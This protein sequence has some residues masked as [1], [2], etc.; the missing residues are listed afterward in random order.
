MRYLFKF[1]CVCGLGAV[2][3]VG[4]SEGGGKGGSGGS[5]GSGGT[6]GS[7]GTAGSG[8]TGGSGVACVDNVC[9]C[10][11]PGIRAAISEGGGPFTFD[12]DGPQTVVTEATFIINTDVI[13]D[14]E[15]N[16]TVALGPPSSDFLNRVFAF[17]VP[18]GVK[19]ELHRLTTD[20]MPTWDPGT[21]GIVNEGTLTIRDCVITGHQSERGPPWRGGGVFNAG[22]MTIINST[23]SKNWHDDG[24][25]GGIY[26]AC[27]A[28]LRLVNST[29][30][31]NTAG[32]DGTGEY[33]GGI[34]N[35]G[36]LTIINSTVSENLTGDGTGFGET[37]G[38]GIAN[39]GWMSLTNST[40]FGNSADSAS[41]ISMG[42]ISCADPYD[43][44]AE[45]ANTLIDGDCGYIGDGSNLTWISN[46]Y[47]IESPGDTCGFDQATDQL[48][49]TAAE[50]NL[51]PLQNNGG[52][53]ETHALGLLPTPSVAID[54]IPAADCV[55]ADGGLLTDDQRGEPR[56]ET[57]GSMCDVGA[58]EVQP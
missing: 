41:A 23:V 16:L 53:T 3:L 54:H 58:F 15:G 43:P 48:D 32:G 57:G 29:V 55:D 28:T 7:G 46:G 5:A 26:N 19:A 42:A 30:S 38:G 4:C 50:L 40:V 39:A 12:C 21:G 51:G 52:L 45:I 14:G 2:L 11:G 22:D 17:S 9:P 18:T 27:D 44:Y 34:Y 56:P 33:G 35:A 1:I 47:N 37:F 10:T 49:V 25:G 8:G 20:S 31:K 24:E 36:E 6:G 13:L